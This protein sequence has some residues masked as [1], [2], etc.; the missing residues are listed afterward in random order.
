MYGQ[1]KKK[2]CIS[3]LVSSNMELIKYLEVTHVTVLYSTIERGVL[4]RGWLLTRVH[5]YQR[6]DGMWLEEWIP[7][8]TNIHKK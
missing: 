6:K 8:P 5:I 1:Q 3:V 7:K 4:F 2:Y